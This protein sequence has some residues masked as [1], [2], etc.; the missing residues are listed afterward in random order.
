MRTRVRGQACTGSKIADDTASCGS[1]PASGKADVSHFRIGPILVENI[2]SEG[3]VYV[4]AGWYT[5]R[6]TLPGSYSL[7][8]DAAV[9][10][11]AGT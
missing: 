9:E 11:C 4:A 1:R 8:Y 10:F 5:L 2:H 7:A 3:D 6:K